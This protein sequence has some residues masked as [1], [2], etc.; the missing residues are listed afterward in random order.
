[1]PIEFGSQL[2]QI[3][4]RH[5]MIILVRIAQFY[6]VK[7]SLG[8]SSFDLHNFLSCRFRR[9]FR[10]SGQYKHLS[11][12]LLILSTKTFAASIFFQIIIA[13]AHADTG[14]ITMQ[15]IHARIHIVG[16][17]IHRKERPN[18]FLVELGH[19]FNH[20]CFVFQRFNSF[21]NRLNGRIAFLVKTQ[22]IHFQTIEI[23]N[24]LFGTALFMRL[25]R[26]GIDQLFQLFLHIGSQH[27]KATKTGIFCG[28]RILLHPTTIGILIKILFRIDTFVQIIKL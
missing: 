8:Q 17:N 11:Y 24:F 6:T 22:A 3:V 12:K 27:I 20:L 15:N 25:Q 19:H 28:Q 14:L 18:A 1:M 23:G 9:L 5:F 16:R 7:L 2:L 13:I 10:I 4:Q 26:Q 21:Q